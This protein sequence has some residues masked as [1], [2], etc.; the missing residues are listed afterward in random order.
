MID[1][2]KSPVESMRFPHSKVITYLKY[3]LGFAELALAFRVV[4]KFLEASTAAPIVE[5]LYRVTDVIIVPFAGIFRDIVL[6]NGSVIDL[7]ALSAMV[8]YPIILYLLIELLHLVAKG[9][10]PSGK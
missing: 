1:G 8:G 6:R 3:L 4:L 10:A 7:N 2:G 5:L 9:D